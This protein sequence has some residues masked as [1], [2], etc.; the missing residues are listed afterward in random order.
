LAFPLN[1]IYISSHC[2]FVTFCHC[3]DVFAFIA[4]RTTTRMI[5]SS[6]RTNYEKPPHNERCNGQRFAITSRQASLPAKSS[7]QQPAREV[8]T[9][10]TDAF[11][12]LPRHPVPA[13]AKFTRNFEICQSRT[14]L[15]SWP[16]K[17]SRDEQFRIHTQTIQPVQS[18]AS[19]GS[20]NCR[21]TRWLP[22]LN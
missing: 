8:S 16:I 7:G 4:R 9:Q 14:T 3:H 18:S 11:T 10:H 20:P 19:H 5:Q 2:R 12:L 15:V 6:S 13:S 21:S 17:H 22:E 1:A